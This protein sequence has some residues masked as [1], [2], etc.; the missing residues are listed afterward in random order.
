M[1]ETGIVNLLDL[2]VVV[3]ESGNYAAVAV[4]LLHSHRQ[5]L[6]P[7]CSEPGVERRDDRAHGVLQK[8]DALGVFR[9]GRDDHAADA[10]TVP[11]KILR[12]RID[13]KSTRLNSSHGSI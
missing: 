10:V 1:W 7:A 2:R 9:P 5:R 6:G 4:V 8:S 11:V 13:R 3:E 12:R